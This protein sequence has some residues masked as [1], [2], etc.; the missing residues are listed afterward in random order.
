MCESKSAYDCL[1]S[2]K[3]LGDICVDVNFP[4]YLCVELNLDMLILSSC[5]NVNF[6]GMMGRYLCELG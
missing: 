4:F 2:P 3:E 5:G 6:P 1:I